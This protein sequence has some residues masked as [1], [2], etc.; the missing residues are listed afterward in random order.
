MRL[1]CISK[2]H[3]IVFEYDKRMKDLSIRI[4]ARKQ[5]KKC[6][7]DVLLDDRTTKKLAKWFC[8]HLDKYGA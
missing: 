8:Q 2:C 4:Y 7:G 1:F 6:L 5:T 3:N